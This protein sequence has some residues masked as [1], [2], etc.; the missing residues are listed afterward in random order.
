MNKNQKYLP[1]QALVVWYN[2]SWILIIH[3]TAIKSQQVTE[4][5]QRLAAFINNVLTD[6]VVVMELV[7]WYEKFVASRKFGMKDCI[8]IYGS[9]AYIWYS[10]RYNRV[11]T[12]T[13]HKESLY[14]IYGMC[15][16]WIVRQN[17]Y[18]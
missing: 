12:Q 9:P 6:V 18:F 8:W 16:K 2:L 14:V 15:L 10:Q 7:F 5:T 11:Q 17:L 4:L 1:W 13:E 3:D